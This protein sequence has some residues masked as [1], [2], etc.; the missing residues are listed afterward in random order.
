MLSRYLVKVGVA[1]L[2]VAALFLTF[3]VADPNVVDESS[4]ARYLATCITDRNHALYATA[5]RSSAESSAYSDD[6]ASVRDGDNERVAVLSP[7]T[8]SSTDTVPQSVIQ[9]ALQ[10]V[11]KTTHSPVLPHLT[12][13]GPWG[14]DRRQLPTPVR[15]IL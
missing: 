15:W 2:D 13:P 3:G 1:G 4:D 8:S 9:V 14:S 7:S 6:A 5:G 10:V 11:K 12:R